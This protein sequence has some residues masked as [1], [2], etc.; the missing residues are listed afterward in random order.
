MS[1]IVRVGL[2]M[3]DR[4][5]RVLVADVEVDEGQGVVVRKPHVRSKKLRSC[6]LCDGD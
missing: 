3:M 1:K 6:G 5:L 2:G 4:L